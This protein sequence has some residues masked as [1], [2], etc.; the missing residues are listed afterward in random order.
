MPVN[1]VKLEE[2]Q[3]LSGLRMVVVPGIPSPWGEAAK[4]ILKVKNIPYHAVRLDP[5]NKDMSQ[6]TGSRSAPVALYNDEAPRHG[7][8]DILLLAERLSPEPA[9][10]PKDAKLRA[11]AMGLCHEICGEMG[12]GWARRLDSVHNG[13]QGKG[14]YAEPIAQY[15]AKKYSYRP[16]QAPEYRQRMLDLLGFLADTLHQ[17][18]AAGQPFYLGDT[19]SA[20][21]LYSATFIA[22]FSP[23]P[24]EQCAMLPP[25]RSAFETLDESIAQALDPI[26]IKHR[27]FI[28]AEFLELPLSL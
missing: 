1:Y 22:T 24:E 5:R 27:D 4:G 28:Y 11:Q 3:Q 14:G 21:D 12:L 10:L 6:W 17:Q 19:L 18:E 25:I 20:V 16:E 8:A 15:L 7:W 2:A 26:L 23:L 9:L 13:L